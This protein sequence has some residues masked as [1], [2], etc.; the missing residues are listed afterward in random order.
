MQFEEDSVASAGYLKQAV[1]LMVQR[2]IPT[3]PVNFAL[4]YSHV[5]SVNKELSE[6]LLFEFP[7]AGTYDPKKSQQLFYDYFVRDH[8][9][10]QDDTQGAVAELLSQLF[11]TVNKATEGT[12]QYSES[13]KNTIAAVQN[14]DDPKEV[15][16]ALN[17]LLRDTDAVNRLTQ[18][19]Q[20]HLVEARQEVENLKQQLQESE[21]TALLDELTQIGNRRAFDQ[22]IGRCLQDNS[23]PT[24]LLLLDLD[25]FK[26]CNDTYGHVTGD[27][28][29]EEVGDVLSGMRQDHIHPHRYGGEEFAVICQQPAQQAAEVA[30]AIRQKVTEISVRQADSGEII[31]DITVSIGVAQASTED[32]ADSLKERADKALYQAKENGRNRVEMSG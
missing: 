16:K 32:S 8:L 31:N 29:L 2:Q 19:F 15:Q 26:K 18:D 12:S 3:N 27:R 23:Q 9:P 1:P 25:H 24:S 4:W 6:R 11:D 5:K 28:I 22:T 20:S 7:A 13:L 21:Q 17:N 10:E 30:E 14:T